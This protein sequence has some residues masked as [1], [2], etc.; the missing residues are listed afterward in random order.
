MSKLLKQ[1]CCRQVHC[2]PPMVD[3]DAARIAP[4]GLVSDNGAIKAQNRTRW[5]MV[6]HKLIEQKRITL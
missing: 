1:P 5:Q 2:S 6:Q 3:S 4:K